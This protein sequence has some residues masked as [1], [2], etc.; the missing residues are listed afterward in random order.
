[1]Q[2][3]LASCIARHSADKTVCY[4][5][6]A[7]ERLG[8]A[9]FLPKGEPPFRTLL[10]I[11]GGG[12]H[13]RKIFEDQPCWQG[14]YLGF[15]ARYFA[16]R[17]YLCACIDYRLLRGHGQ[18]P[19]FGL[20]E[21]TQDCVDAAAYLLSHA[22]EFGADPKELS[23]LGESAG[24][25]LAAAASA[26]IPLRRLILVNPIT[27]FGLDDWSSFAPPTWTP[28]QRIAAHL[29]GGNTPATLLLHGTD[30]TVV[31]PEHS[32]VFYRQMQR[33]GRPCALHLLEHARHA[34]L[35]AEYYPGGTACCEKAIQIIQKYLEPEGEKET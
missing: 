8:L 33:V 12:W 17:G 21:L 3:E 18:E 10:L 23:L 16:D 31:S 2:T 35:L 14:D 32:Y 5:T 7:G 4:K 20:V 24:G 9:L 1:M 11:H 15:L 26:Q 28:E 22:E 13:S 6:V 34:F 30:D 25:Y 27:D 19:G 29:V